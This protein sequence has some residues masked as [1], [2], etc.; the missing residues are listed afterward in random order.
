MQDGRVT[1]A[2][3]DLPNGPVELARA[4]AADLD[5][6]VALIADDAIARS[7]G[8]SADAG[9]GAAY[10]DAFAAIDRDRAQLLVVGRAGEQ[11]VATM[12][13][14]FIPGLS[15]QGATRLQ[16]EAVRVAD[17]QRGSGLGSAMI[18]WAL[19]EGRRRGAALAQLTSDS[20]RP[21]AHTFYERLGFAATHVGFK[22]Q[23]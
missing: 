17:S 3:L 22:Q 14:S 1:L 19:D 5:A 16:I 7:R 10:A 23:L 4:T 15:R 8:D 11:V 12:Q 18:R 9:L 21:E 2:L 20:A 13:L 6:L